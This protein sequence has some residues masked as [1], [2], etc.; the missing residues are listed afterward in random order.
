MTR[1]SSY[2]TQHAAYQSRDPYGP[3][4]P[5][6]WQHGG[7]QRL[8]PGPGPSYGPGPY[9][10]PV[11]GRVFPPGPGSFGRGPG[12]DAHAFVGPLIATVLAAPLIAF[13]GLIMMFSPMATDSCTPGGCQALNRALLTAPCVLFAAVVALGVSWAL[14]WRR[15]Y[16]AAR[17]VVAA[18]SPLLAATTLM[19]YFH[20]PAPN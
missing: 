8:S 6:E 15:S 2:G 18:A 12:H 19:L 11:R 14:P 9:D 7:P 13:C 1:R 10:A 20:L 16:R 17:L 3:A 5:H 4:R